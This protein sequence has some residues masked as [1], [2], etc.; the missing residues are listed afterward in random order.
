MAQLWLALSDVKLAS[1]YIDA[2]LKRSDGYED[3]GLSEVLNVT[4][5]AFRRAYGQRA[6]PPDAARRRIADEVAH[7]ASLVQRWGNL[8]THAI[9]LAREQKSWSGEPEELYAR[10][11]AVL[12]GIDWSDETWGVLKQAPSFVAALPLEER[13]RLG[14]EEHAAGLDLGAEALKADPRTILV[15]RKDSLGDDMGFEAGDRLIALDGQPLASLWD[16]KQKIAAQPGAR[17][18]VELERK[19]RTRTRKIKIPES[20]PEAGGP[21]R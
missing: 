9:A 4:Y 20:L 1:E 5:D 11:T 15:V 16:F 19:G 2:G 3:A 18:G 21:D 10:A 13:V 14:L 6:A 17:L 12:P 7:A 8:V